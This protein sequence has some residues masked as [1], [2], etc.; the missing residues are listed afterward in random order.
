MRSLHEASVSHAVS[1]T[2]ANGWGR[3]RAAPEIPWAYRFFGAA[4][5]SR[6][7]DDLPLGVRA[8]LGWAASEARRSVATGRASPTE[9]SVLGLRLAYQALKAEAAAIRG[10]RESG[11][12]SLVE[13]LSRIRHRQRACLLLRHG[14]NMNESDV[15]RVLG[16]SKSEVARVAAGARVALAKVAG[17]PIDVASALR[18][19]AGVVRRT[20]DVLQAAGAASVGSD[21]RN[22]ATAREVARLPRGVTRALLAP[23]VSAPRSNGAGSAHG[24]HSRRSPVETMLAP[25]PSSEPDDAI[26]R[27]SAS[28]EAGT[29]VIRTRERLL[30]DASAAAMQRPRGWSLMWRVAASVSVGLLFGWA[31]W[32]VPV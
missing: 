29:V 14:L 9:E 20:E 13:A 24:M 4:L 19:A 18:R 3:P 8:I 16:I 11:A 21:A 26:A 6:T 2:R 5:L 25:Y 10:V 23:P 27:M 32:P 30:A 12:G 7:P 31:V 28:T 15:A 17:R 1:G 22:S